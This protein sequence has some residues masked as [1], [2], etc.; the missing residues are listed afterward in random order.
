MECPGCGS[1]NP[2]SV[3]FCQTCGANLNMDADQI[4]VSFREKAKGDAV[5]STAHTMKNML[6][7]GVA[8]FFLS[9]TLY[10][11]SDGVPMGTYHQIP[12]SANGAK[13]VEVRYELEV[14]FPALP[15]P[16]GTPIRNKKR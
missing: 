7:F 15:I 14:D 10:V 13:H 16:L 1:N 2:L 8:M 3:T 5:E 6:M 11:M 4:A 9:L 12:S